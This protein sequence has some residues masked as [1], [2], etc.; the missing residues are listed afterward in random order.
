MIF[1]KPSHLGPNNTTSASLPSG[2][3]SLQDYPGH[4]IIIGKGMNPI[5]LPPAMGK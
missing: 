5:I 4:N 1:L 3:T 2:K